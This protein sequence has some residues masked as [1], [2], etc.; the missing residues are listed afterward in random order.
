[1]E[2]TT[3]QQT[4]SHDQPSCFSQSCQLCKCI[5]WHLQPEKHTRPTP[6]CSQGAPAF[7]LLTLEAT[8]SEQGRQALSTENAD[9]RTDGYS[10]CLLLPSTLLIAQLKILGSYQT[11]QSCAD[12][13]SPSKKAERGRGTFV[14]SSKWPRMPSL[15]S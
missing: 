13:Q 2:R 8:T 7:T 14:K 9:A 6:T 5:T 15:T 12:T 3:Q 11:S 4:N 10:S 1:M